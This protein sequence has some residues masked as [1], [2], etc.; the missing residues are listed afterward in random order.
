M[1]RIY[2]SLIV[3]LFFSFNS[4][5]K[6]RQYIYVFDCTQS[7]DEDYDIWEPAN[8]WLKDDIERKRENALITIVPF[9]DNNDGIIGPVLKSQVDWSSLKNRFDYLISHPHSK[10]GI[11]RAW[12]SAIPLMKP[13]Y[14][15]WFILLT[16]GEDGYDGSAKVKEL[17]RSWCQFHEGCHGYVVTLSRVAK[18]AL[19]TDLSNCDDIDIIDGTGHIPVIG[20]FVKKPM[21]ML[22]SSPKNFVVGFSEEGEYKGHI[23]CNDPYY[24]I[25]LESNTISNE[26]AKILVKEKK[27][28]SQNHE[29][30]FSI[31]SDQEGVK[32]LKPTFSIFVDT[33]DL[34]NMNF[35]ANSG[36][37]YNGGKDDT[38]DSFLGYPAKDW[39]YYSIKL[40]NVLNKQAIISNATMDMSVDIPSALKNKIKIFLDDKEIDD[41]FVLNSSNNNSTLLIKVSHD[42]PEDVFSINI[43]G[44]GTNIESVNGELTNTYSAKLIIKHSVSSNPLE[45]LL[46]FLLVVFVIACL[47]RIFYSHLRRGVYCGIDYV[48]NGSQ[49]VLVK[50]RKANRIV[51]SSK[52]KKQNWIDWLF[53]GKTLYNI[54][55][56]PELKSDICFKAA[57]LKRTMRLSCKENKNYYL[58]GIKMR[59]QI[60]TANEDIEHVI[61]DKNNIELLTLIV[62]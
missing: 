40:E 13:E 56:I 27:R 48:I 29:I 44:I 4:Y 30:R 35:A 8:K 54:E 50:K 47:I 15:N 62:F 38:Y 53:N 23:E 14:E 22:A 21:S 46:F 11:C 1:C 5:S 60:L 31:I 25:T 52:V 12:K 26:S 59:K 41:H 36:G 49:E 24:D 3:A 6:Q 20:S 42:A 34:A 55:P 7:M 16:D 2:L 9:R 28:P 32:F 58:D 51:I 39:A 43:T 19:W 33:R 18:D 37:E 61:T 45:T 10:T 17:M 57:R